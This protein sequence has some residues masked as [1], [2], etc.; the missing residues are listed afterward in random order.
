VG[1]S[2]IEIMDRTGNFDRVIPQVIPMPDVNA[3]TLDG[4]EWLLFG[5]NWGETASIGDFGGPSGPAQKGQQ[6]EQPYQWGVAQPLDSEVWYANRLRVEVQGENAEQAQIS[7]LTVDGEETLSVEQN[8]GRAIMHRDPEPGEIIQAQIHLSSDAPVQI[9]ATWPDQDNS[10]TWRYLFSDVPV[11]ASGDISLT[12]TAD[13]EPKLFIDGNADAN[14]PVQGEAMPASWDAPDFVWMVNLL[15]VRDIAQGVSIALFA[16]LLP[17]IFFVGV[18]YWADRYEKEPK[19]LLAIVFLWGAIPT[20]IFSLLARFF[21]Q[22]PRSVFSPTLIAALRT[23]IVIPLIEELLK[24]S[25]L[26]F[27]LLRHRREFDNALDGVVYGSMVGLGYGMTRNLVSFLSSFFIHGFVG[28]GTEAVLTGVIF[29]LNQASYTAIFGAGLGYARLSQ[30]DGPRRLMPI[31]TF[32]LAVVTHILHSLV[33]HA[34]RGVNILTV[35][36]T[37]SGVLV[38]LVIILV[39]LK[40]QQ[41]WMRVELK[42]QIP[43]DLYDVVVSSSARARDQW[44]ALFSVGY[45]GWRKERRL[46]QSCTE[47]AFKLRQVR[48]FPAEEGLKA[49]VSVLQADIERLIQDG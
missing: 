46:H 19:R 43:N 48:L 8:L 18:V 29:T 33:V 9:I 30:R 14:L 4:S 1:N 22:F 39:S 20:L 38:T 21:I 24:G 25:I 45:Q 49:E 26:V 6:W 42:E 37:L 10:Q 11:S 41:E 36:L 2:R 3:A 40:R 27:I 16:A 23:G 28:L 15:P 5:G 17:V 7:L 35:V 12:L 31:I 32:I 13:S 44:K 47:L 34:V